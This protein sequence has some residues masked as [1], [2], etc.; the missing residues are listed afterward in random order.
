MNKAS[1]VYI[2]I[3]SNLG[4][5][6]KN[7][8]RAIELLEKKGITVKKRSSLYETKPWGLIDQPLYLNMA[9]EIET[10]L[11]PVQ[12]LEV[13]KNIEKEVGREKSYQWGP[14]I[15][16]LDILLFDDVVVQ[17]ENL[18]IP[19]PLMHER[20]FVLKPLCE[21]APGVRHPILKM[22]ACELLQQVVEKTAD[23]QK[24]P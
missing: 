16:D 12:L 9:I 18:E 17:V 14:R 2:G 23:S 1:I 11:N 20:Y 7:C 8:F 19:H 3:G 21:I 22:N 4:N 6:E 10:D 13:L 24:N 5:R 15:L